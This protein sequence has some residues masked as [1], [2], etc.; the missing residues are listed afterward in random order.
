MSGWG[1]TLS[2]VLS[3]AA[4]YGAF[5]ACTR[6]FERLSES[7]FSDAVRWW[8]E[9]FGLGPDRVAIFEG[10]L[11][12][13]FRQ[14]GSPALERTVTLGGFLVAF[15]LVQVIAVPL[16][17]RLTV[18]VAS[19]TPY[20]QA[21][22]PDR[23]R[24]V[25]ALSNSLALFWAAALALVV[26]ELRFRGLISE[27]LHRA[28]YYPLLALVS[29]VL[30]VAP[31]L[32]RYGLSFAK[33]RQR[34]RRN[35]PAVL[36]LGLAV[37]GLFALP[38][39]ALR[40][41]VPLGVVRV[42]AVLDFAALPLGVIGGAEVAMRILEDRPTLPHPGALLR[43]P[44]ALTYA[45]GALVLGLWAWYAHTARVIIDGKQG[46]YHCDYTIEH[47]ELP[48][49]A[50]LALGGLGAVAGEWLASHGT[51][52]QK[53]EAQAPVHIAVGATLGVTN[54]FHRAVSFEP[55][56][57]RLVL[58]GRALAALDADRAVTIA[59]G[60]SVSVR[61]RG[62]LV[63]DRPVET[64]KNLLARGPR[65]IGV[66]LSVPLDPVLGLSPRLDLPVWRWKR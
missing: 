5:H 30:S 40:H 25:V 37:G 17:D 64:L 21:H 39:E 42:L 65:E 51:E 66:E 36:G 58:D 2:I 32:V 47:L 24:G 15:G 57:T 16:T 44:A 22:A 34:A 45:A 27:P 33:V 8:G 62:E 13:K 49:P 3:G 55:L 20:G 4:G 41:G 54:R 6:M 19:R 11:L 60:D 18:A 7:A 26:T 43:I 9:F 29:G 61:L 35:L 63:V 53:K 52:E 28:L 31:A 38:L 48:S 56:R 46:L 12:A 23:R 14:V 59:P 1:L 10:L 50:T